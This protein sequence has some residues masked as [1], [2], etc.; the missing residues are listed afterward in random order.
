M[1][2]AKEPHMGVGIS[3]VTGG[4]EQG[5]DNAHRLLSVVCAVAERVRSGGD[6]LEAAEEA[7]S[8]IPGGVEGAPRDDVH[9]DVAQHHTDQR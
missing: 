6:E 9:E 3:A 8:C 7:R 2:M 5:D 1:V 4:D